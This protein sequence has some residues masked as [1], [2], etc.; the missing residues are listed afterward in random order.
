MTDSSNKGV[1]PETLVAQGGTHDATTG[2][3][4][5]PVHLSTTFARDEHYEPINPRHT[6]IRDQNPAFDAPEE[7]IRQ[8]EGGADAL[9]FASGMAAGM[10]VAQ[11]LVPGDQ[12]VV[13]NVMYWALRNWLEKFCNTWGVVLTK[14][15]A[16]DPDQAHSEINAALSAKPSPSAQQILWLESPANPTWD[17]IDV[18]AA[19]QLAKAAG[20]YVVIDSTVATPVHTRPI[21]LGADLVMHSATKYLNGHSD[22][23]AGALITARKDA[24]WRRICR[25]RGE[26]GAIL[27]GFEAWLLQRGLRTLFVRVRQASASA[28]AIAK[29]F[30]AHPMLERVLYPGLASHPGHEIA[31]RQMEGGFGGMLSV[32]VKGDAARALAVTG[33]TRL[34]VRATSLGGV[35]SLIE[36]R[37]TIEGPTSPIPENLIRLSVGI[38]HT[39]DLIA[40]LE[41]AL[42]D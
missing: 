12:I 11:A 21:E 4:I 20:A 13:P 29:H 6:Y 18:A 28:F 7:V 22:V 39:A 1:A 23:A 8:L 17:I 34:F 25:V 5:P 26:Y 35:E 10:S 36:H 33:R 14:Y 3:V 38:E 40:D 37:H 41:Q 24:L 30:E 9:L 15:D 2:A 27:G 31:C 16:S 19:S 32:V 42:A